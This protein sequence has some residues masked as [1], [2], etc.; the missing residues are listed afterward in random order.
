MILLLNKGLSLGIELGTNDQRFEAIGQRRRFKLTL[1]SAAAWLVKCAI[2]DFPCVEKPRRYDEAQWGFARKTG[3]EKA[4]DGERGMKGYLGPLGLL[5]LGFV[6][7][8]SPYRGA[9]PVL[10]YE[11]LALHRA[12]VFSVFSPRIYP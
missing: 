12:R 8:G 1:Q 9:T 7:A 5:A 10:D 4:D 2:T 6:A 3:L 11:R